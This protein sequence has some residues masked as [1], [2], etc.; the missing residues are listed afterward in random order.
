M[1]DLQE[2]YDNLTSEKGTLTKSQDVQLRTILT[3]KLDS[4]IHA[5]II[6]HNNEK[7][8]RSIWKAISNYF[9]SSQ[10]SNRAQVFKEILRLKFNANDIPGFITNIKTILA[11][12]HEVGIEIPK[13]IVTYIILD[14]L[15]SALDTNPI[16]GLFTPSLNPLISLDPV[17]AAPKQQLAAFTHPYLK[18]LVN[19][20]LTPD[21][22]LI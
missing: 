19:S 11:L 14:K 21:L 3:S 4:S 22:Q 1:L 8:P 6:N 16:A 15:P 7:N 2:L 13:D 20:S 18:E 9:A 5:N 17:V 12:F 10:A